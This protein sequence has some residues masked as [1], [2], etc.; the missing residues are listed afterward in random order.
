MPAIH[1]LRV[2][3]LILPLA[4]A[5]DIEQAL[6]VSRDRDDRHFDPHGPTAPT[7]EDH[8]VLF[9]AIVPMLELGICYDLPGDSLPLLQRHAHASSPWHPCLMFGTSL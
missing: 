8:A 5:D 1:A 3:V 7:V 4:L 9:V 2:T 6:P